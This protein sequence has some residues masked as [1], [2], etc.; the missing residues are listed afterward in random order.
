MKDKVIKIYYWCPFI[1]NV[2]TVKAVYNSVKSLNKFAQSKFKGIILD[3]FGE[4]EN[5]SFFEREKIT[6]LKL[7][8]SIII[9]RLPSLGYFFSRLKYILIFLF[10]YLP[11]KKFLKN[12][13]PDFLI[14][15]LMTSLP[16][17]LNLIH[18][19]E[20]KIILRISG[21][22]KLNFVR[23][24]FWKISLK[25]VFKITFPTKETLDY[26]KDLNLVNVSKLSLLYD[27][28]ISTKEIDISKKKETINNS[29]FQN[30]NYFLAIGRLT[31]Q[32][33]FSFLIE[34]F[35]EIIKNGFET[36]L[37]ILGEGEEFSKLENLIKKY[38]IEKN[39]ILLGYK[40]NIYKYLNKCEAFILSSLWEDPGFVI[41]EAMFSGTFVI[42]SNC[43]SGPK[44]I[45]GN[46]RGLLFK[47]NSKKDFIEK[48][49]IFHKLNKKKKKIIILDAKKFTKKFTLINHY[50]KLE[51]ILN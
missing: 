29:R 1:S 31:K 28:I 24:I 33:N 11:L 23:Y 32:K 30:K 22:P 50:K 25:K 38:N 34:C 2:A 4:W 16:L 14:I 45:V 49:H 48:F 42:S 51:V 17:L 8:H 35:N 15:H 47:N 12:D 46:D 26:F 19:F 5:S 37:V 43:K 21:K 6:I 36:N 27:P 9:Q 7:N 41:L 20:T 10:S 44:E 40:N 18:K 3:V 13:K 39:I